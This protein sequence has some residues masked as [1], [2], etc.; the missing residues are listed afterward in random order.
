MMCL[1]PHHSSSSITVCIQNGFHSNCYALELLCREIDFRCKSVH[2]DIFASKNVC[3][4]NYCAFKY[5]CKQNVCIQNG[6]ALKKFC[7]QNV[8]AFKKYAFKMW[9]IQNVCIQIVL[10]SNPC[11]QNS[12]F[13]YFSARLQDTWSIISREWVTLNSTLTKQVVHGVSHIFI[14]LKPNVWRDSVSSVR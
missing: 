2:S 9:C 11:I 7:I 6:N 4:Q 5:L 8:C 10:R 1:W 14:S 13:K 12:A 3:I